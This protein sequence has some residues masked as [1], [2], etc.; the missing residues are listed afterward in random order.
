MGQL[1]RELMFLFK[2]SKSILIQLAAILLASLVG[3]AIVGSTFS[4]LVVAY[5]LSKNNIANAFILFVSLLLFSDSI[6][7]MF[8]NA[9]KS[10]DFIALLMGGFALLKYKNALNKSFLAYFW[11]YLL[12]AL[13]GL[14][15]VNSR[16]IGFQKLL[17]YGL[18]L[19]VVPTYLVQIFQKPGAA[20][21]LRNLFF[22]FFVLYGFS[23]LMSRISPGS[24]AYLGRFNGI[25]RN[26]NGVGIFSALL[27][28][29]LF[30]VRD[31]F[32]KLLTQK[33]FYSFVAVFLLAILL[34]A[35]RNAMLSLGVFFLFR[36]IRVNF[37]VGFVL[38]LI[39]GSGY[40]LIMAL[41]EQ[42]ATAY[43]LTEE[44]RVDTLSYASGRI[45]IWDACWREIQNHF[46]IGHGFTYEEYSKWDQKYYAEIPML[47]HNYGNIHS[48]YLTIWLNTGFLGLLSFLIGIIRLVFKGQKISVSIAP[49]FFGAVIIGIFES[50]MVASL[51]PYTWQLWFGLTLAAF[52][53]GIKYRKPMPKLKVKE[54]EQE[55]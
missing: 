31:L 42:F 33:V 30:L 12:V 49:F 34:A 46:W 16:L 29:N 53:P 8:M 5:N 7:P 48:S 18:L 43:N 51:N 28:M 6:T 15:F 47:I 52:I 32:P 39:I 17:S 37:F 1:F 13:L 20:S 45:Y 55:L 14:V 9:A 24:Y 27:I 26:P 54:P 3:G 35:S 38:V 50:Y 2:Q 23:I 19:V 21:F 4:F 41:V 10:K 25:H 44:V 11:P 36:F 40:G 22:V